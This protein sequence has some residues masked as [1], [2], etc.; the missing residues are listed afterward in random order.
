MSLSAYAIE[1][2]AYMTSAMIDLGEADCSLE[3]A[4]CKVR[5]ANANI[6]L[7]RNVTERSL[8]PI[9]QGKNEIAAFRIASRIALLAFLQVYGSEGVW[10]GV[11][12]ALQIMGGEL[13]DYFFF[14][15]N[16]TCFF[17]PCF[18]K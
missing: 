13:D 9:K 12:E 7:V 2:M 1:S 4:M 18:R 16:F 8:W 11:N 3:A 17:L 5:F 14:V 15:L 10:N 6:R